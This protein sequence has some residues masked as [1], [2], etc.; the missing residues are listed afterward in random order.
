MTRRIVVLT[1][2]TAGGGAQ[3][4]AQRVADGLRERGHDV[5][6]W[7]LYRRGPAPE[8]RVRS[9]FIVD[10]PLSGLGYLTLAPRLFAALRRHRPDAVLSFLPLA[11]VVG[12]SVAALLGIERRVVSHR[13]VCNTYHPLLRIADRLLGSIGVYSKVIAVSGA[14]AASVARYPADYVRRVSVVHN[15][16][17]WRASALSRSQARAAFGLPAGA[18]LLLA[19]GRLAAQKNYPLLVEAAAGVPDLV[20]VIAGSGHQAPALAEQARG[21]GMDG[22]LLLL[23]H[24]PPERLPDLY[25]ACDVFALASLY[26]GQSN[27]LLE[28]MAE[29][30]LILASDIPEQR[31]TLIDE[32]GCM[33]GVLLPLNDPAAWREAIRQAL[34]SGGERDRLGQL[35]RE[36]AGAFTMARMIGGFEEAVCGDS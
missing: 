15:G 5:E 7:F 30:M 26:E 13:S 32:A 8:A 29:G 23:G 28:A 9:R 10:G 20:L 14:V 33:A 24:L 3:Q 17:D 6:L 25:R 2:F 1:S 19:V 12:Q 18:P 11:H 4:A 27:A 31:E 36:R 35:A 16:V 22:R 34:A 21:L